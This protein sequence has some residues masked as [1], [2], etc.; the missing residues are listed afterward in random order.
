MNITSNLALKTAAGNAQNKKLHTTNVSSVNGIAMTH[1]ELGKHVGY[2]AQWETSPYNFDRKSFSISKYANAE[3][4]LAAASRHRDRMEDKYDFQ[5][6]RRIMGREPVTYVEE[7]EE[8]RKKEQIDCR[9]IAADYYKK[10]E[11]DAIRVAQLTGMDK[12]TVYRYFSHFAS[13]KGLDGPVHRRSDATTLLLQR[14]QVT[15]LY[16]QGILAVDAARQIGA[17]S[18]TVNRWYRLLRNGRS[19][20][21]INPL[22]K[23]KFSHA[24]VLAQ[25]PTTY[26]IVDTTTDILPSIN[27]I[28]NT[29]KRVHMLEER[30][31]TLEDR[32]SNEKEKLDRATKRQRKE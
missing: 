11:R 3:E 6:R 25:Q 27:I 5:S 21:D 15:E 12:T 17:P 22:D 30:L 32:L 19:L 13:G 18:N 1:D 10:G 23:K 4:T 16:N 24:N 31:A 20:T 7:E 9:K 28:Q 26:D 29:L 14:N 2:R 8:T